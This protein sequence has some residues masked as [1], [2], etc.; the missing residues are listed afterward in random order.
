MSNLNTRKFHLLVI[1]S[2]LIYSSITLLVRLGSTLFTTTSVGS[3]VVTVA[4]AALVLSLTVAFAVVAKD[5]VLS[6]EYSEAS[7]HDYEG[8]D[9]TGLS[10]IPLRTRGVLVLFHVTLLL[11]F[12]NTLLNAIITAVIGKAFT[13]QVLGVAF[14]VLVLSIGVYATYLVLHYFLLDS[15]SS[16]SLSHTSEDKPLL[17]DTSTN[18]TVEGTNLNV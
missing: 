1:L 5:C 4:F 8:T 12:S 3:A 16:W 6:P 14:S 9:I 18:A 10:P 17:F 11:A 15:Y 13:L 7:P 2:F